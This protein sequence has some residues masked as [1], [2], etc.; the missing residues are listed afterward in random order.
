MLNLVAKLIN[1]SLVLNSDELLYYKYIWIVFSEL[2][3]VVYLKKFFNDIES[4]L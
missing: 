4:S 2:K 3:C 1:F